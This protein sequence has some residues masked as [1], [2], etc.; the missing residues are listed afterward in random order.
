MPLMVRSLVWL[1]GAIAATCLTSDQ[2]S[3]TLQRSAVNVAA[4]QDPTGGALPLNITLEV[5][6]AL[7]PETRHLTIPTAVPYSSREALRMGLY[8]VDAFSLGHHRV[9]IKETLKSGAVLT[10][11]DLTTARIVD[12]IAGYEFTFS[13]DM[14]RV[15]YVYR[16]PP[17]AL[18]DHVVVA[19]DFLREPAENTMASAVG[20][21]NPSLDVSGTGA[22]PLTP[23]DLAVAD[24]GIILYP[25]LNQATGRFL[26]VSQPLRTIASPFAWCG[27]ERLAFLSRKGIEASGE[28]SLIVLDV[29][30]KL[31]EAKV[32]AQKQLDKILFLRPEYEAGLPPEYEQYKDIFP[33]A[34]AIW[35]EQD[36]SA[37]SIVPFGGGPWVTRPVRIRLN[38]ADSRR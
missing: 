8:K 16:A 35:F 25:P 18:V 7:T 3:A 1:I 32:T 33:P 6:D 2:E 27:N 34:E 22:S 31:S 12:R 29:P 37:V 13:T 36:C 10:I 14:S 11:V 9:V 5:R 38:E 24:R 4:T 19:Y 23:S 17:N 21:R 26:S 28:T 30:A 15:A 20:G